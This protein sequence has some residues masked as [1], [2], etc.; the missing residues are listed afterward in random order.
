MVNHLQGRQS[1]LKQLKPMEL[2]ARFLA[3]GTAVVLTYIIAELS[4]WRAFAGMFAAFPAVMATAVLSAGAKGGQHHAADVALGA[5]TGMLGGVVCVAAA[6]V[7]V[8][9]T[10]SWPIG[11][12][13]ALVIWGVS[14]AALSVVSRKFS[15]KR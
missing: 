8:P 4:P 11:L 13:L 14:S 6:I 15:A 1:N 7:L 12:I 10:R 3:G 2:A 5:V 9:L